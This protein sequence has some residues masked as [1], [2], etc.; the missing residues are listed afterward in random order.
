MNLRS[1]LYKAARISGDIEAVKRGTVHKRLFNRWL[2]RT[3][4]SRMWWR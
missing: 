2:G 1:M 3:I 4:I